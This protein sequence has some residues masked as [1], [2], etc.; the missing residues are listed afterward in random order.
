MGGFLFNG[1]VGGSRRN[2]PQLRPVRSRRDN[3]LYPDDEYA[4]Q[5]A[6]TID[7]LTYEAVSIDVAQPFGATPRGSGGDR[8]GDGGIVL[9]D[10]AANG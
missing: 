5:C 9:A 10:G 6:P 4:G 3:S 8:M 1:N 2:Q 7:E